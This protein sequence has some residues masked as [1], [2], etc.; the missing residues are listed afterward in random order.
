MERHGRQL[1]CVFEPE[2][3]E[4]V[5]GALETALAIHVTPDQARTGREL[6]STALDQLDVR[7]RRRMPDFDFF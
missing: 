7:L 6:P 5:V 2:E 3:D 4:D 1:F